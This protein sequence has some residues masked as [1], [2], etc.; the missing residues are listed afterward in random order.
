MN[1]YILTYE[2]LYFA[3]LTFCLFFQGFYFERRQMWRLL[4][5][6]LVLLVS[7]A[8]SIVLHGI[9]T[10]NMTISEV[11]IDVAYALLI[12]YIG[13]KMSRVIVIRETDIGKV[14]RM[15]INQK[16]D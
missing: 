10:L 15:N 6:S 8:I 5:I 4:I 9:Y 13:Y 3:I 2:D 11:I 14:K 1:N 7:S 16:I 12:W